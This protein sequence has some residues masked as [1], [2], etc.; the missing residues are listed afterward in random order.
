MENTTKHHGKSKNVFISFLDQLSTIRPG[1]RAVFFFTAGATLTALYTLPI[2]QEISDTPIRFNSA[3][4]PTKTILVPKNTNLVTD[5]ENTGQDYKEYT[6]SLLSYRIIQLIKSDNEFITDLDQLGKLTEPEIEKSINSLR[7]YHSEVMTSNAFIISKLNAILINNTKLQ[8][9]QKEGLT[10]F[11]ERYLGDTITI[12]AKEQIAEENINLLV[13]AITA[14]LNY[15]DYNAALANISHIKKDHD[16]TEVIKALEAKV[17]SIE[18]AE[19]IFNK[20]MRNSY[21]SLIVNK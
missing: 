12:K 4:A 2:M 16:L 8:A 15:G 3:C 19:F 6:R 11:S 1:L 20:S 21:N 17:K 9:N 10:G 13:K 18:A 5:F 14:N 7:D